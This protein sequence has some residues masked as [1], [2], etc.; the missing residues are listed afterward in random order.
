MAD[1][2]SFSQAAEALF[3]SQPAVTYQVAR[4]EEELGFPLFDRRSRKIALTSGGRVFYRRAGHLLG[5]MDRIVREAKREYQ[6][7]QG[8]V[9]C[10]HFYPENDAIF[11]GARGPFWSIAQE[12]ASQ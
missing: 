3:L 5:E 10:G 6:A 4:L 2:R 12:P 8:V 9:A 7:S 11:P 1:R